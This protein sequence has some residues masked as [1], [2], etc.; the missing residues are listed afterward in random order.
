MGASDRYGVSKGTRETSSH[1][2]APKKILC[3][4]EDPALWGGVK[5]AETEGAVKGVRGAAPGLGRE[6]AVRVGTGKGLLG[7][8]IS[9]FRDAR[10]PLADDGAPATV[11]PRVQ[12]STRQI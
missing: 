5:H 3:N 2:E 7:L 10:E 1:P 12:Q 8:H 11:I 6:A 9:C 4:A